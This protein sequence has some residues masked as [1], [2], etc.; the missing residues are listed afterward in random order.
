LPVK[1]DALPIHADISGE[2]RS[3]LESALT[4]SGKAQ[5]VAH[6][7]SDIANGQIRRSV[8]RIVTWLPVM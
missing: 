3:S 2:A 1:R 6:H 7:T 5:R 8:A 4:F